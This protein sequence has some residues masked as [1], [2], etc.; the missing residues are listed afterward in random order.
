MHGAFIVQGHPALTI[1]GVNR[2]HFD[3]ILLIVRICDVLRLL[4]LS[5][6]HHIT[7][8]YHVGCCTTID[9]NRRIWKLSLLHS[10]VP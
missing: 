3:A 2:N 1:I 10:D 5:Q 8:F 4:R 7:D 6:E 9:I